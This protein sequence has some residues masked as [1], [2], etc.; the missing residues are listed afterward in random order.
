MKPEKQVEKEILNLAP[1]YGFDLTVVDS[2]HVYSNTTR[3]FSRRMTNEVCSDI[4][5]NNG[6]YACFIELK[7]PGKLKQFNTEKNIKQKLFILRKIEKGAF[8]C[9][10]DSMQRLAHIWS[11][12]RKAQTDDEKIKVLMSY[13]P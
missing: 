10:V 5:G 7:A 3:M 2:A 11:E 4:M 8:A 12:W 13:L 9:V 6:P 1:L